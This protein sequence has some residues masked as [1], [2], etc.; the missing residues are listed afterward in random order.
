MSPDLQ[1]REENSTQS[2]PA[3][4]AALVRQALSD[5]LDRIMPI[6]AKVD[7]RLVGSAAALV[8]GVRLSVG[9]IDVLLKERKGVDL[10]S[11]AMAG[12]S[13][14]SPP[15]HLVD[16]RQY[17]AKHEVMGVDVEFS[18]VEWETT[19]DAMECF[20]RGPWEHF[21]LV[22]L[23]PHVV[24]TVAVELRLGSELA[25]NRR[26]QYLVIARYLRE[27]GADVELIRRGMK[28]WNIPPTM[29]E[30]IFG[31]LDQR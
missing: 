22:R 31:L 18:T 24:P 6:A 17:F 13:C 21:S 3:L 9:D 23:G 12:F 19:S 26:E 25:R 27:H 29:R 8:C 28:A 1:P 20:G 15:T 5:V 2:R 16:A 30:E 11:G 7:F 10:F 4:D 14:L